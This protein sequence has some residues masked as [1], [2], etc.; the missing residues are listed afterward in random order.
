[1]VFYFKQYRTKLLYSKLKILKLD[2]M[3]AIDYTKFI[4]KF[5]NHMLPDSFN[6]YFTKL[7]SVYKYNIKQ[8]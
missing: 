3:I 1:M 6:Y 8:N 7:D 2:D 4:F 5:N